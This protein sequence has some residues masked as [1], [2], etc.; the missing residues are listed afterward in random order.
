M[1][2]ARSLIVSGILI[3]LLISCA[4]PYSVTKVEA[5]LSDLT[6]C[7]GWSAEGNPVVLRDPGR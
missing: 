1:W 6:L 2:C 4:C 3:L 5:D 7:S